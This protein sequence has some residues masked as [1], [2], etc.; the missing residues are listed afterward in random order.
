MNE[1]VYVVIFTDGYY[2]SVEAV[3]TSEELAKQYANENSNRDDDYK[4]K[5]FK[6]N[7]PK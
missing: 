5:E 4:I 2:D 6:L 7:L 3:F 1:N